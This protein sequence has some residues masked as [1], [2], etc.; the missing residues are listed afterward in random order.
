MMTKG[1]EQLW[2]RSKYEVM[3][4][5]QQHYN[6]IRQLMRAKPFYEEVQV[7]IEAAKQIAP[8]LGSM[9]NSCDHMWGYFKRNVTEEE[10]QCYIVLE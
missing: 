7:Q 8:T 10:K 1:V 4:H 5:S 9:R 3:Y 2:A 6:T